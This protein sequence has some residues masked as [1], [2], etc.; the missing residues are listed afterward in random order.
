MRNAYTIFFG[1]SEGKRQP[2]RRRRRLWDNI[3]MYLKEI[4]SEVVD[5]INMAQNRDQ[6]KAP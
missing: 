2:G 3:K 1:K 4:G 5:W 6:W